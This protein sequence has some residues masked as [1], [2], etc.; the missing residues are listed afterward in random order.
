MRTKL[1]DLHGVLTE[2]P[3]RPLSLDTPLCWVDLPGSSFWTCGL[4]HRVLELAQKRPREERAGYGHRLSEASIDQHN[5]EDRHL[6]YQYGRSKSIYERLYDSKILAEQVAWW[7]HFEYAPPRME[8]VLLVEQ[9]TLLPWDVRLCL[10]AVMGGVSQSRP[11]VKARGSLVR[12]GI[13]EK[14][15]YWNSE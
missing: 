15:V 10:P 8:M 5:H 9:P 14:E 6:K 2:I 4:C 1:S 7:C 12:S 13:V 11:I 3:A